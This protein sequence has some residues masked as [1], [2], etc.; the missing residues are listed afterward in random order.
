[1]LAVVLR[2][3]K[4]FL[5]IKWQIRRPIVKVVIATEIIK[6]IKGGIKYRKLNSWFVKKVIATLTKLLNSQ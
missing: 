1:V 5:L 2:L 6:A 4:T 3:L